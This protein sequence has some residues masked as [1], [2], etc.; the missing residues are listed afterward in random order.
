MN[1]K[2]FRLFGVGL[3]LAMLASLLV[4]AVTPVSAGT[5]SWTNEKDPA[6]EVENV[7]VDRKSVV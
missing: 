2:I 5:L 7:L 1:K 4:P 6:D 3:T